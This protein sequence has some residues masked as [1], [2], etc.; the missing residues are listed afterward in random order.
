MPEPERHEARKDIARIYEG[1]GPDEVMS[2]FNAE[3]ARAV[4]V[5]LLGAHGVATVPEQE[6][7]KFLGDLG[8][9]T[10][11]PDLVDLPEPLTVGPLTFMLEC[12]NGRCWLRVESSRALL[13]VPEESLR[14]E[15]P[16]LVW[17]QV[18]ERTVVFQMS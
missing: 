7:S 14:H 15:M 13:F 16:T 2:G 6:W 1:Y 3:F 10:V 18:D 17:H 12:V 9:H 8:A 11:R 5:T 4:M